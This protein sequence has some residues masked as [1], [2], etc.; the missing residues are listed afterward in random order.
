MENIRGNI[1]SFRMLMVVWIL[2][3]SFSAVMFT[4]ALIYDIMVALII[5]GVT[6]MLSLIGIVYTAGLIIKLEN[7]LKY[8][9]YR[10]NN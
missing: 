8:L 1:K 10:T 2:A 5:S 6:G 7:H 9:E 4:I 3:I